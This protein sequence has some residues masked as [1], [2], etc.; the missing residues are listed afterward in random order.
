VVNRLR[1]KRLRE[2]FSDV[3]SKLPV[4]DQALLSK[5]LLLVIDN[6]GLLPRSHPPVLGAAVGI[7]LKKFAAFVYLSPRR[8]QSYPDSFVRY[9]IAHELA[10]IFLGHIEKSVLSTLAEDSDE[11]EALYE[12]EAKAQARRWGYPL[13]KQIRQNRMVTRKGRREK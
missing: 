8:L 7:G 9:V 3:W 13:P 5:R 1:S 6:S 10:H 11:D 2:L 4:A 12:S